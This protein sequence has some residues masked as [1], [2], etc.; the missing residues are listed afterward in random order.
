LKT[1]DIECGRYFDKGMPTLISG[2]EEKP[3]FNPVF[4]SAARPLF[5]KRSIYS[6]YSKSR[7]SRRLE[8]GNVYSNADELQIILARINLTDIGILARQSK[9][10]LQITMLLTLL[11]RMKST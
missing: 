3:L 10:F 9:F 2:P 8:S 7:L 6:K 11:L 1:N 4:N 5:G